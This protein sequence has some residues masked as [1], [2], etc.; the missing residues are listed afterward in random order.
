[1]NKTYLYIAGMLAVLITAGSVVLL[2]SGSG[3]EAQTVAVGPIN[4]V[5][6]LNGS[7]TEA[8][9]TYTT[10]QPVFAEQEIR[11]DSPEHESLKEA[12]I[13][14][15]DI[16]GVQITLDKKTNHISFAGLN[17][18]DKISVTQESISIISNMPSD[19]SGKL[20]LNKDDLTIGNN[21][22]VELVAQNITACHAMPKDN[23]GISS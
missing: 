9:A 21:L 2:S 13:I 5:D 23:G 18:R 8:V 14:T 12:D 17:P 19:W 7:Y 4:Y 22:C 6:R 16:D 3:D 11:F 10:T 1:M 15:Y 20:T